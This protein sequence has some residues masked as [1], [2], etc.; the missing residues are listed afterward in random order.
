ME[1]YNLQIQGEG[2]KDSAMWVSPCLLRGRMM[3]L[4]GSLDHNIWSE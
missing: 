2:R 3:K 4:K 1:S